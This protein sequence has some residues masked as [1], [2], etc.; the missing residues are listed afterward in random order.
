MRAQSQYITSQFADVADVA[1]ERASERASWRGGD[2]HFSENTDSVSH[3]I[4]R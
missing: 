2:T 1:S 3:I 4:S